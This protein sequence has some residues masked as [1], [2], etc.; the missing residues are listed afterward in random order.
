MHTP[1]LT[2]VAD[3]SQANLSG[4]PNGTILVT[5]THN[6]QNEKNINHFK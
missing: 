2:D 5:F 4:K 1:D 3:D 6:K